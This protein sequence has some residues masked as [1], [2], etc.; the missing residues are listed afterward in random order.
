MGLLA[1]AQLASHLL[2]LT[3][4]SSHLLPEVF[5]N[6]P[7][8]GRFNLTTAEASEILESADTHLGA[9]AVPYAL[10][11]HEDYLKTCLTMLAEAGLCTRRAATN[12][13]LSRQHDL[14]ANIT[15]GQFSAESLKHLNAIR[16]MRNCMIHEGGRVNE[17]LRS[18]VNSWNTHTQGSWTKFAPSLQGII[19]GDEIQFTHKHLILT[20]AVTKHLSREANLLLQPAIPTAIW[21]DVVIN[22]VADRAGGTLPPVLQRLKKAKGIARFD[23]GALKLTD[24]DLADAITRFEKIKLGSSY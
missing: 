5:P 9:M 22:D 11:L 7:H 23:Y 8:I 2:K 14:I 3:E 20:L 10:A 24:A 4:G 12:S 19:V 16:L 13:V 15:G 18:E 21:A 1:G 6:V 17:A